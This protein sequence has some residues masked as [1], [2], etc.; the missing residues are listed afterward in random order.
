MH[1]SCVV[2]ENTSM[3]VKSTTDLCKIASAGGSL[4]IHADVR[5]TED[6]IEIASCLRQGATITMSGM[7][8][9]PTDEL[10]TIAQAAP[11]QIIFQ[12]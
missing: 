11:G 5:A 12:A 9:R 10:C 8:L 2:M 6:L 3:F 4:C 1:R 7:M